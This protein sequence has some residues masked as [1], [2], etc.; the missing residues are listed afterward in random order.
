MS[1]IISML[2]SADFPCLLRIAIAVRGYA[3]TGAALARRFIRATVAPGIRD[4]DVRLLSL[5]P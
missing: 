4:L 1:A 3:R 5:P 2:H